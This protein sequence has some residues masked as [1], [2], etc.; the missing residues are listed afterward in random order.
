MFFDLWE[1]IKQKDH[2]MK[3]LGLADLVTI[4]GL[5][6]EVAASEDLARALKEKAEFHFSTFFFS[7]RKSICGRVTFLRL[8]YKS[9]N[10]INGAI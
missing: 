6:A 2:G 10:N 9:I 5:A 4:S 3:A 8:Q 7:L 1:D